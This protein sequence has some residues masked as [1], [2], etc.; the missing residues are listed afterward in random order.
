MKKLI[1]IMISFALIFSFTACG[2]DNSGSAPSSKSN[3][4]EESTIDDTVSANSE[5]LEKNQ[6][7]GAQF[8]EYKMAQIGTDTAV[9]QGAYTFTSLHSGEG[10][11]DMTGT[12]YYTLSFAAQFMPSEDIGVASIQ[13]TNRS[14]GQ[15]LKETETS[16]VHTYSGLL[17]TEEYLANHP[18]SA[19][20]AFDY[21]KF[22]PIFTVMLVTTEKLTFDD[23]LVSCKY[24]DS[25]GD[26]SMELEFNSKID[27]LNTAPNYTYRSNLIQLDGEYYVLDSSTSGRGSNGETETFWL[28]ELICVSSPLTFSPPSL[29]KTRVG[30]YSNEDLSPITL[31]ENCEFYYSGEK[32]SSSVL[33]VSVG[34]QVLG[35][36]NYTA[37]EEVINNS[38]I[39]IDTGKG[40]CII[41]AL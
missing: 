6:S 35:S 37:A 33:E 1:G 34:L 20:V 14:T 22:G 41:T 27:E 38:F 24:F 13:V 29:D 39:G 17:A 31:P 21:Y 11:D 26:K 32:E 25:E 28:K 19:D 8:P 9:S 15:N 2:K 10:S 5:D 23:L 36:G 3:W 16:T 18:F 12:T 4:Q 7:T 30:L 40:V